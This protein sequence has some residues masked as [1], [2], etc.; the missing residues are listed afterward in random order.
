M[1][2]KAISR[3]RTLVLATVGCLLL[4]LLA[5]TF[6]SYRTPDEPYLG[7]SVMAFP[8]DLHVI[9]APIRLSEAP[10]LT[11]SRGALYADGN[12]AAGGPIS[13]F[14]LDAPVFSFNASGRRATASSLDASPW[15]A[16]AAIEPLVEQLTASSFDM[17]IVRRGTL[18]ITAVDGTSETI[19]DID[20]EVTGRRKGVTTGRGSFTIRG[21]RLS[22]DVTLGQPPERAPARWPL[23]AALK[24]SLLEATFDGHADVSEDLQLAGQAEL[25]TPSLRRAARWFGVLV[26]NAE[27]L[28]TTAMK[29]QL[30]WSRRT[31][32]IEKA[33]M[34]VDG[35]EAAGA[36][37]LNVA[38]ERPLIDGT[39]GFSAL[40]LTAYFEAA[41]SQSLLFDRQTASWST[42]DL[43][44]PIIR[45]IDADLR[46]S[47]AKVAVA[48]LGLGRGAATISVR[49]G[50]L[51]ADIAE[52]DL[53]AGTLSAQVTA[54]A[55]ELVPQYA[56]R[57]K[58]DS[59][60]A[61]PATAV[62]LGS[63]VL[64]GRSTLVVD[65]AG[66]G[67]TPAEILR[68]L[69]G[70]ASLAMPE[71]GRLALDLKSLRTAAKSAGA[72][73]WGLLAKGSTGLEQ[74]EARA[75]ISNGVLY[76]ETLRARSGAA[77]VAAAG[78]ADLVDK[79]L[80]LRLSM[81]PS[82]PADQPL[83]PSD[84]VGADTL[85]VRGPWR[86]PTLGGE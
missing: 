83:K 11:L 71:G 48:G 20:A 34:T 61:A 33:K 2:R 65:I 6:L 85:R 73:G 15:A 82:V 42:Y 72:P 43:S 24:G 30:T 68:G 55:N 81:K 28:G 52:L 64:A 25:V 80:D 13:K 1:G 44:F 36:L 31:L 69:S 75:T 12:A 22:F 46:I 86:Q 49:S 62:L 19:S 60:E 59:F 84:M 21:Q 56:L 66:A 57:G 53:H 29:G 26:P 18:Y 4:A 70:K 45:H 17:L 47:A 32:T 8:R 3:L 10:D 40:D 14:V 54:N 27:G 37:S 58:I 39:L 51:L 38:G 78:R 79:T 9:N 63:A 76:T 16:S 7:Y 67:Q 5:P 35:N 77:A 50:K 74:V 23:K 41:R